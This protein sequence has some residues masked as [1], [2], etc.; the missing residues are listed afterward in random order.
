MGFFRNQFC[1][2][3]YTLQ[4]FID[5]L[6]KKNNQFNQELLLIVNHIIHLVVEVS[7]KI[8]ERV[9]YTN[10]VFEH[11][12]ESAIIFPQTAE[13][14]KLSQAIIFYEN[15]LMEFLMTNLEKWYITPNEVQ[16]S[17]N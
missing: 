2:C 3:Q 10:S 9:Q 12:E 7:T 13:L 8:V 15:V 5:I 4:N 17:L 6:Y 14:N 1:T 16:K 11:H